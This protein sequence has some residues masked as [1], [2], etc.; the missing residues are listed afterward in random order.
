MHAHSKFIIVDELYDTIY[1]N[2][3]GEGERENTDNITSRKT[4]THKTLKSII[5]SLEP[6]SPL[7]FKLKFLRKPGKSLVRDYIITRLRLYTSRHTTYNIS[8]I[9]VCST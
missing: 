2:Q 8:A 7:N 5:T 4:D 9:P 3:Q 1:D 6:G